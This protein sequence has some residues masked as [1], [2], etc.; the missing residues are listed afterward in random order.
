MLGL[1]ACCDADS[2]RRVDLNGGRKIGHVSYLKV[3]MNK[4]REC[5]HQLWI[6]L[7]S[8]LLV[9]DLQ[10]FHDR[11]ALGPVG[12]HAHHSVERICDSNDARTK[13]NV[14]A[15]EMVRVTLAVISLMVV[16]NDIPPTLKQRQS[17][18]Q[19]GGNPWVLHDVMELFRA[20]PWLAQQII[21]EPDLPK[22]VQHGSL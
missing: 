5:D 8:A 11:E 15:R 14:L 4:L 10:S 3:C 20:Q 18:Q 22:V 7:R 6:E 19:G 16:Q 13:R 21:V 1:D 2:V 9:Q 12:P 17:L